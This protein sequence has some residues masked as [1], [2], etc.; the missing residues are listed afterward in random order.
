MDNWTPVPRNLKRVIEYIIA[1]YSKP[2][3]L[4]DLACLCH[5][6]KQQVIRYFKVSLHTTPIQYINNYRLSQAKELLF[7]QTHL[8]LKEIA[9]ELGYENPHYF[10]RLFTSTYGETPS[11]HRTR[12]KNYVDNEQSKVWSSILDNGRNTPWC[13][14]STSRGIVFGILNYSHVKEMKT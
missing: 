6:S 4:D 12:I 1:N 2:I 3:T 10:T 14:K 7:R 11:Q 5:V 8:T 13:R 9:A